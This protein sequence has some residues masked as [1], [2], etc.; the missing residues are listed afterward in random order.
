MWLGG[1]LNLC[2]LEDLD[3]L[4]LADLDDRLLPARLRPADRAATLRLR[5]DVRD[6][7]VLDV[8]L[9]QRVD[10]S[11]NDSSRRIPNVPAAACALSAERKA[12]RRAL[13]FTLTSKPRGLG[14]NATPP[15]VNCGARIVPARARPVPFWRHGF[16]RPPATRPRLL[17]PRVAERASFSSARTVSWTRCGLTSA[18]KTPSSSVT[19]F[20]DP[21]TGALGAATVLVL[22]DLDDSVARAGHGALDEEQVPLRVDI[23]HGHPDLGDALAAHPAGPADALADARRRRRGTDRAGCADVVRAMALR[24]ALE[25]VALD[26]A[27]EALADPDP[28]DLDPLAGLERLDGDGLALGQLA[29]PAELDDLAVRAGLAELPEPR[30]RHPVLGNLAVRDLDSLVAVRPD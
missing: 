7:H 12:E 20:C 1:A 6:A 24:A 30:L 29:R 22:S 23:V 4:A 27:G 9:E 8:H 25:V 13:R 5:A 11:E 28:G 3:R 21:S 17:P 15:P 16:E 19:V 26:R 10:G 14:G 2:P 18:A